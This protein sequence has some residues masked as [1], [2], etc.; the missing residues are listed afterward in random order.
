MGCMTTTE[1]YT[2]F[3][4]RPPSRELT[5]LRLRAEQLVR[6]EDHEA[7]LALVEDLRADD[8]W[9]PHLW[10]PAAAVA[11]SKSGRGDGIRLLQSA[12]EA[13]F[14]QPELMEGELEACFDKAPE[15]PAL[16]AGMV[17]NIPA[18]RL[19]LHEWP[20]ASVALP[21]ELYRI[22]TERSDALRAALPEPKASAWETAKALLAWVHTRWEH[23]NDHV[24]DPDALDVLARVDA[25]ERFACVEYS[26]VLSQALNAVGIP[27]RRLDLRQANHH[28]GVGRG[29]VVSEGWI[30][31]LDRWVVLDGQNGAYWTDRDGEPL[32]ALELQRRLAAGES[33]TMVG[34]VE[35]MSEASAAAWFSYFATMSTTGCVWAPAGFAP[36]FQGMAVVR[37]S[38]LVHDGATAYPRLSDLTTGTGGTLARPVARFASLHPY[39]RGYRATEAGAQ[40]V[41]FGDEGW[42]LSM[43]PG[44]HEVSLAAVTDFG[45]LEP[46]SLVYE[47][48]EG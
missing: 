32:G 36:I 42:P 27:G 30:D 46:R 41:D 19:R 34:L 37:S 45:P 15:W 7:L 17:A 8:E 20:V 6:A 43:T 24:E 13:G 25:G 9:W 10:G 38:R 48:L 16:A 2:P 11:A 44:R 35:P 29:H 18:P 21:L 12:V 22:S 26:I 40:S 4:D 3:G 14:S 47:V 1:E 39:V 31:D 5:E 33:A 28:V 23:A